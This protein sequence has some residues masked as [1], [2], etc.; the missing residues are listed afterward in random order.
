[1]SIENKRPGR[2]PSKPGLKAT[3]R[4]G[5]TSPAA[6]RRV[7]PLLYVVARNAVKLVF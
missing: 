6:A 2:L 3:Q 5:A 7:R 4:Q 1:M